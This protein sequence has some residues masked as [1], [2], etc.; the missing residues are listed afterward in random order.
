[1]IDLIIR[2]DKYKFDFQSIA[3]DARSFMSGIS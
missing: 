1:M 2:G 3:D